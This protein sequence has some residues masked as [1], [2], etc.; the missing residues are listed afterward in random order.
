MIN[1]LNY[2]VRIVEPINLKSRIQKYII[3][4][5]KNLKRVLLFKI[6]YYNF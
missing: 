3:K 5:N 6:C 4:I 2:K 1:S